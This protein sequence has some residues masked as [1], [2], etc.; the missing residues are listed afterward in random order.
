MIASVDILASAQR[1]QIRC[2]VEPRIRVLPRAQGS[3]VHEHQLGGHAHQG[4]FDRWQASG[5]LAGA[6]TGPTVNRQLVQERLGRLISESRWI[7]GW[8]E[9]MDGKATR[10][11][12]SR[13]F[14]RAIS[15]LTML[16]YQ[17]QTDASA[18]FPLPRISPSPDGSVDLLWESPGFELLVN[19][20]AGPDALATFAGEKANQIRLTGETN[21]EKPAEILLK[22]ILTP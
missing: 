18:E 4:L 21:P 11:I 19:V 10:P 6:R 3:I 22:W 20:P 17:A 7:L 13:T 2:A 15:L 8:H 1:R 16:A 12:E 9:I 5:D 14:S